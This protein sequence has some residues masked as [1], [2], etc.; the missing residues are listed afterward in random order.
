MLLD[1]V[2]PRDC[3]GCHLPGTALCP[4]CDGLL[5]GAALGL[6]RPTPCPPGLPLLSAFVAY[7][8]PAQ[9]LLLAHKERGQL[10]LTPV[11]ATALASAVQV[12]GAGGDVVLCPVPSSRK[13]VRQRGHDHALRL[14]SGAAEQLRRGGRPAVARR[15]L[16]QTRSLADQA[17]LTT[18]Q[19]AANLSGALVSS[20]APGPPVVVVDDVVTTGATLVE[21]SRALRVAGH[22]VIGAAVVAATTRRLVT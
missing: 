10:G 19:R 3:A 22:R 11:L 13:V 18:V 16:T 20:V 5:R 4:R 9:Q 1:L 8:G 2:L 6:V 14:A 12:L 15:L 17:G 7:E 21:A